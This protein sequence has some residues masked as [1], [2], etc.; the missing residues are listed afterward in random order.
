MAMPA[1]AGAS[2]GEGAASSSTAGVVTASAASA[3]AVGVAG[4]VDAGVPHEADPHNTDLSAYHRFVV[5]EEVAA[6]AFTK[7]KLLSDAIHGKVY[8]YRWNREPREVAPTQAV[9][10]F[11]EALAAVQRG[12]SQGGDESFLTEFAQRLRDGGGQLRSLLK[13]HTWA[14]N[15]F[16]RPPNLKALLSDLEQAKQH[17][18]GQLQDAIVVGK[19]MP[20]VRVRQND[21]RQTNECRAYFN[22][23]GPP[24]APHIEDALTEIG[25]LSYLRQQQDLPVYLLRLLAVVLEG[26]IV[27][28]VTEFIDSELFEQVVS[29]QLAFPEE[30]VMRY[31]WQLLQATRYLHS[32]RIGHRDISLEN[33]LITF[34]SDLEGQ[35]RLMDFGQAVRTH[36]LCGSVLLRYFIACGKQYYRAPECYIPRQTPVCVVAPESSVPGDVV[37]ARLLD[38][39]RQRTGYLC[40]VRLPNNAV[41]G[42]PCAAAVWGYTVP[43]LDVFSCG[44]ALFILAWKAPPWKM[45]LL[46]DP[47]F[48][49]IHTNGDGAIGRLVQSWGRTALAPAAM[50]LLARM[51]QTDPKRRPAVE[52]CLASPWFEQMADQHVPTHQPQELAAAPQ[53]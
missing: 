23:R 48:A 46:S 28:M 2:G 42:Q 22:P 20:S 35:I 26:D 47:G 19:K 3:S 6:G 27:T 33:I 38:A 4:A 51:L 15:A 29:G 30:R 13:A 44:V 32:H 49:F 8:K 17:L 34:G 14:G 24:P 5:F 31:T 1:A 52:E 21:G 43:P 36:S 25:A 12:I 40:E 9:L 39:N 50:Q 41:P 18:L 45:A 7:I 16:R 11:D 53:V 37:M 10:E